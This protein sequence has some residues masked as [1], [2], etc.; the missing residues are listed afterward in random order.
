MAMA[1]HHGGWIILASVVAAL[2]L[3]IVVLPAWVAPFRPEW[4]AMVLIYWCL[5]LPHRVSVGYA[6]LAGLC[7]DVLRGALL[8][9][10]ALGFAVAAY[11]AVK[12]HQRIRVFPL[13]QQALSVMVLVALE[14]LL[15]LWVQGM[16]G[17]AHQGWDYWLPSLAS[18]LLWPWVF[19]FLRRLRRHF[20]VS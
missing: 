9:Q 15:V 19:L 1:R 17:Q 14:Q 20:R 4:T 12:L 11:L 2:M 5:A 18:G 13:W 7:V 3:T 8:G 10:H 6:W 16:I